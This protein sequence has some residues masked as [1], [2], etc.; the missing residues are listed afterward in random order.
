MI[1]KALIAVRASVKFITIFIIAA[2]LIIGMVIFL[3][4]PIYEVYLNG[5]FVGYSEDKQKLQARITKYVNEG[6]EGQEHVAFVQ[7]DSMPTYE[8]CLL[9]KD[10]VTNDEEIYSM[11]KETGTTYYKYYAIAV[12]NEEQLNVSTFQEAETAVNELK[13]KNSSNADSLSIIEKYDVE[14]GEL[15]QTEEAIATLYQQKKVAGKVTISSKNNSKPTAGSSTGPKIGMSFRYPVASPRISSRYGRRWG[16][17]HGGLDFSLPVGNNIYAS[18]PG[19]VTYSGWNSGGYGY[20]VIISHGNGVQTY[21]GHNSSLTCS[22]GQTV[23]AGDI[24][25]KSGNTGRSTGPHCHFE[26]RVNGVTYNP[27][28]YL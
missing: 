23:S 8:L 16:R 2:L 27:E 4:K 5:E 15:K 1:R 7:L 10:I 17:L 22:V 28:I 19:T 3:Y 6:E 18:A 12:N 14:M 24:I 11:I 9:K 13:Q 21:Y 25:A 20:L 26:I